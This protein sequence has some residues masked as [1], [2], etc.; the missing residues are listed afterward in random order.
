MHSQFMEFFGNYLIQAARWQKL[1]EHSASDGKPDMAAL[2]S[3]FQKACGIDGPGE[4]ALTEYS[5]T[6]QQ[7]VEAFQSVFCNY[8][9]MWG[10]IPQADY[11]A[12]QEKCASLEKTI[13][14][15]DQI[16]SQLRSLLDEKGLGQ[17]EFLQRFQSLIQDQS[18]EF[19]MFMKNFG[20]SVLKTDSRRP[21]AE[22]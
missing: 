21:K 4:T 15:K 17:S 5:R 8:A 13:Q 14:Q 20:D 1:V 3:L 11:Q 10:W 9:R 6:W 19:Q 12:L 2:G 7:S 22:G 18:D 16:I